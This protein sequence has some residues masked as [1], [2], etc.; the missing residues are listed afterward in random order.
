MR[1]M[2][3]FSIVTI[4]FVL[5]TS[6]VSAGDADDQKMVKLQRLFRQM[7][8]E[9]DTALAENARLKGEIEMLNG[10]IGSMRQSSEAALRKSRGSYDSLN[11]SLEQTTQRLTSLKS[12]KNQ[13]QETIDDQAKLIVSYDEKNTKMAQINREL[14]L[15]YQKKGLFDVLLQR[16]PLT[17]IKRVEIE[18]IVQ[19]YQDNIDRQE[20]KKK[21]A[22]VSTR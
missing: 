4:M 20:V 10:K 13:L 21:M 5:S 16:E 6:V 12:E 22:A 1:I 11:E 18:N 8:L 17:Q 14:L 2:T 15:R 9:R 7:S 19:E 3:R